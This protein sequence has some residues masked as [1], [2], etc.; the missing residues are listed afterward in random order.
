MTD[1]E[2]LP[3]ASRVDFDPERPRTR[4]GRWF[5]ALRPMETRHWSNKQIDRCDKPSIESTD[6]GAR[7]TQEDPQPTV[8]SC[9]GYLRRLRCCWQPGRSFRHFQ[10]MEEGQRG[11]SRRAGRRTGQMGGVFFPEDAD[12]RGASFPWKRRRTMRGCRGPDGWIP[13]RRAA[14]TRMGAAFLTLQLNGNGA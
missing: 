8:G 1:N 4:A 6:Q 13:A 10:A 5:G 11:R 12:M 7:S 2:R 3:R 9:W 14:R